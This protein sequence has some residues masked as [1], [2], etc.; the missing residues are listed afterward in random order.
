[1]VRLLRKKEAV[2]RDAVSLFV[3]MSA[4]EASEA[5]M[6]ELLEWAEDAPEKLDA[7]EALSEIWEQAGELRPDKT[8]FFEDDGQTSVRWW[9]QVWEFFRQDW[10]PVA[11]VALVAALVMMVV[12][13]TVFQSADIRPS[14]ATVRGKTQDIQLADGSKVYLNGLSRIEVNY[15]DETRRI[16]M[17]EGEVYFKVAHDTARP[18]VV[19][20]ADAEVRAVGT[21]FD[22]DAG[23]QAMTVIVTEGIV[24]IKRGNVSDQFSAGTKVVIPAQARTVRDY[25]VT[26]LVHSDFEAAVSW[27]EGVLNFSGDRLSVALERINRQSSKRIVLGDPAL[28]DLQIFGSFQQDNVTSFLNALAA[29]YG[30]RIE[31]SDHRITLYTGRSAPEPAAEQ[32]T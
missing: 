28:G 32:K 1:M 4:E 3:R 16:E 9:Q 6:Q 2:D 13:T 24:S 12:T 23:A 7:V 14:F 8:L 21:A 15:S 31:E 17:L 20:V 11:G 5:D 26:K 25:V 27:R 19:S 29:L 10:R 30:V 22:I 18:F